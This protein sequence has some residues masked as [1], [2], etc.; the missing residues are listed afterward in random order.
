MKLSLF[1]AIA[2]SVTATLMSM[3]KSANA[4]PSTYQQT[5]N[6]IG[7]S[8]NR[9]SANC[10]KING[11]LNRTS[12]ILRGIENIDGTLRVTNPNQVS[13]YQQSCDRISVRGNVLQAVCRTRDGRLNR[14]S[15]VLNNI[16][17]I[18]GVLKYKGESQV[19]SY[20]QT[21]NNIG[22]SGN[23]L[24]ANC[25]KI[26]GTFNRTSITLQGIEN[27]DGT[28]R[29]TNPNQVSNYQQSCDRISVRGNVLQAV[30][31]TRDGRLNRTS[32]TLKGIE[33][34][35]GVLKYTSTP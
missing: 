28:L 13:N 33:N 34:I 15:I 18:D 3:N 14:T 16:E 25:R 12:I 30:C 19:S 5:C 20:Q 27:I 2:L 6:N 32:I 11:T 23:L 8:G 1:G 4:A 35:N 24:S 10:R 7:I 9:L 29:V 17:N 26:N 21:C 31:R 22:I